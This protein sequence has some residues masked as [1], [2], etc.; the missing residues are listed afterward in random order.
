MRPADAAT[1]LCGI[2]A[3]TALMIAMATMVTS[4]RGAVDA[5]LGQVLRADLYL[6]TDG[7]GFDPAAQQRLRGT[8]G[9]AAIAFSRQIPLAIDPARPPVTLLAQ[10]ADVAGRQ[11]LV[12]PIAR[13][14]TL[15]PGTIP[16]W[17]SEPA[18]RL[19][20]WRTGAA[21]AL[22]IG[23]AGQRFGV[24]GV[25]RDYARQAGA[26]VIGDGDYRRLTGDAARDEAAVTLTPGAVPGAVGRAML[27]RLPAELRSQVEVAEP[28]TLRRFALALFDRSF[29][30]T[31]VLE[32]VAILVGLAGVAATMSA[33]TVARTREFGMLRHLGVAKREI[34]GTLAIEGTILGLVGGLAGVAL[35]LVLSQVLVHVINP[36]S[37][38]WT[39][40]TIVPWPTLAG[41][42]AALAGAATATAVLAGRRATSIDAVLAVR[43]DW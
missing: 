40:A 16:V 42:V 15:P 34:I 38:N 29:A 6:R 41:V 32:A 27:A 33:Q 14:E 5:W 7:P 11:V 31:Y 22:P 8:P 36:Q 28:A 1:A 24:A 12:V 35:G 43:E 17:I 21:I 23:G 2:V 3:S 30:V 37:F 39:M 26:I 9:I 13:A 10:E 18:Q 4:F 25:W 20:G 19:Y